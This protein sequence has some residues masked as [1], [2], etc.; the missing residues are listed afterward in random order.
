MIIRPDYIEKL[1]PFINIKLV[2]ILA[3]IRRCGKSTILEMLKQEL[4]L[5]GVDKNHIIIR[6]YTCEDY[7]KNFTSKEMYEEL[8]SFI[9]ND[10]KY[11]FLLDELQ[12]VSGREKVVNRLL[13]DYNTDIHVRGSNSKHMSS[14]ITPY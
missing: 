8:K 2:K 5:Q 12:E 3:G 6:K 4:L 14:E 13:E 9:K 7:G 1:K 11:Y 10:N